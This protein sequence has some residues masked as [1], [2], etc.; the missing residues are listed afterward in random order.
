MEP[1]LLEL[2]L[3]VRSLTDKVEELE[4]K[5]EKL[6]RDYYYGDGDE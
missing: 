1:T 3:I 6:E 2:T 4:R 5:L